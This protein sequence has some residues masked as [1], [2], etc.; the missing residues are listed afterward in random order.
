MGCY[1]LSAFA[2]YTGRPYALCVCVTASGAHRIQYWH[3]CNITAADLSAENEISEWSII[4]R[5]AIYTVAAAVG[6]ESS[7][8]TGV[9]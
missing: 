7:A 2:L 4:G 6:A 1:S 3:V 8:I 5:L 9:L